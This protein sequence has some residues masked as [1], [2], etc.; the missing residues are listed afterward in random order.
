MSIST[1]HL[2]I[3]VLAPLLGSILAGLFGRQIGR[4]GAQSVTIAGVA[5]SCALSTSNAAILAL[6]A[7]TPS[8]S[9]WKS[10][11]SPCLPRRPP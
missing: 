10:T 5:I 6:A 9:S 11:T 1:T 7:A 8:T 2:L 4:V 3:I